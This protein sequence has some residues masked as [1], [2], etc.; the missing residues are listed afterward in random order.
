[1]FDVNASFNVFKSLNKLILF[2]DFL[3]ILKSFVSAG[4]LQRL[5]F[6]S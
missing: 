4:V 3:T 1:M 2:N 6:S 5:E